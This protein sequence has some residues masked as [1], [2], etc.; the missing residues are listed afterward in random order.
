LRSSPSDN[1]PLL[2]PLTE[3]ED[4]LAEGESVLMFIAPPPDS[5]DTP[6]P[7]VNGSD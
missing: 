1:S 3:D 4:D 7:E 5:N 2:R 6:E